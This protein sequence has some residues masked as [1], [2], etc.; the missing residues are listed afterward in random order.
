[1]YLEIGWFSVLNPLVYKG[2]NRGF[3]RTYMRQVEAIAQVN[4]SVNLRL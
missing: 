1:M 4:A 2:Y 3:Q